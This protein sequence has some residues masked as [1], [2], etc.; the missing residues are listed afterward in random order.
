L[1]QVCFFSGMEKK[2]HALWGEIET[3]ERL[4]AQDDKSYREIESLFQDLLE[5]D[6]LP[7]NVREEIHVRYEDFT[8]GGLKPNYRL[9]LRDI[10]ESHQQDLRDQRLKKARHADRLMQITEANSYPVLEYNP[11]SPIISPRHADRLV[12][13]TEA[14]SCGF[15]VLDYNPGYLKR[16]FEP[17]A[18]AW[19]GGGGGEGPGKQARLSVGGE[20][21]R[22]KQSELL[23]KWHMIQG[24]GDGSMAQAEAD[25]RFSDGSDNDSDD[26]RIS[27]QK[28]GGKQELGLELDD[29][30]GSSYVQPVPATSANTTPIK[31]DWRLRVARRHAEAEGD[32]YRTNIQRSDNGSDF[33]DTGEIINI[34]D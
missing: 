4:C 33:M 21:V 1:A 5:S 19:A 20:A 9:Y 7:A 2:I 34:T 27:D 25:E 16:T 13:I 12:Q 11:E 29:E 23:D 30:F 6:D 31:G 14:N 17:E 28:N 3:I 18:S 24:E 32:D 15:P 10:L 8:A 26:D 22:R